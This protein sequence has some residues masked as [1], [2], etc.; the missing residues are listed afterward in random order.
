MSERALTGGRQWTKDIPNTQAVR[1]D[2]SG[3]WTITNGWKLNGVGTVYYETYW[4]MSAYTLDD[5]TFFP[6]SAV[7]QD[8]QPYVYSGATGDLALT[9]LDIISQERLDMSQVTADSL[10]GNLPGQPLS[11]ENFEQIVMCN[12]RFNLP[13][14]DFT[15]ATLFLP[16]TTGSF[17]SL[18][19]TACEKLWVYRVVIAAATDLLNAN[20]SIPA[21]RFVMSGTVVKE[22][23]LDYMMRL[24]RSYELSQ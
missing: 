24:K 9:I 11:T 23:E 14:A 18:Q 1:D 3:T 6:I 10:L 5:L 20:I 16:A 21:T 4:D 19:P 8:G 13:Q 17:G 22:P 15:S 7:L 2:V 12:F